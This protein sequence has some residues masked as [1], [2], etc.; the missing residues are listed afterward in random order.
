MD[1]L[2]RILKEFPAIW[3]FLGVIGTVLGAILFWLV[4]GRK[5]NP[6]YGNIVKDLGDAE[7]V[8]IDSHRQ[9]LLMQKEYYEQQQD[10][11]RAAYDKLELEKD[12]YKKVSH[13]NANLANDFRIKLAELEARPNVDQVY[14]GQQ[15]FFTKMTEHMDEQT[16][17][18]RAIHQAFMDHDQGIEQ[19]TSNIVE[20]VLAAV[21]N[22]K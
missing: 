2:I 1:E 9:Q 11:Q 15:M 18:M 14:K 21:H 19:R 22:A 16:K 4:I 20:R 6:L 3:A 10:Y 12:S 13:E 17:T 8:L 5:L 7:K